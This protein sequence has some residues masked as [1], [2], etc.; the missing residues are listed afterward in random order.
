MKHITQIA[1]IKGRAVVFDRRIAARR[2]LS[3]GRVAMR[4]VRVVDDLFEYRKR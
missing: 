2:A 3:R 4:W 1:K